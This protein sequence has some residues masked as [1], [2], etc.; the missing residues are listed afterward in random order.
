MTGG[1]FSVILAV[2]NLQLDF[3]HI[4]ANTEQNWQALNYVSAEA[5][6]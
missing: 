3:V 1:L 2:I 4:M 6:I 5:D